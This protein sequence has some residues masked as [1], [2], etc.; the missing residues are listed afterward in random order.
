MSEW[1]Q[2]LSSSTSSRLSKDSPDAPNGSVLEELADVDNQS[3]LQCHRSPGCHDL[4]SFVGP[5]DPPD[6]L[7]WPDDEGQ[8]LPL[9]LSQLCEADKAASSPGVPS[10]EQYCQAGNS[11]TPLQAP[12][13]LDPASAASHEEGLSLAT[14][15]SHSHDVKRAGSEAGCSQPWP[16]VQD[17]TPMSA[18][19]LCL[20]RGSPQHNFRVTGSSLW[21]DRAHPVSSLHSPPA[22]AGEPATS[23]MLPA[24]TQQHGR[25]RQFSTGGSVVGRSDHTTEV[26]QQCLASCALQAQHG[27]HAES[28]AQ[29]QLTA[30]EQL[31]L[32]S[33]L[34]A[35]GIPW[36]TAWHPARWSQ[37]VALTPPP[38]STWPATSEMA[39]DPTALAGSSHQQQ[40][41]MQ[42]QPLPP[43]PSL[44]PP[45][46]F[47][48]GA[49]SFTSLPG[50]GPSSPPSLAGYIAS[51]PTT[52]QQRQQ[53]Q[54]QQCAVDDTQQP[55]SH[56]LQHCYSEDMNSLSMGA[57]RSWAAPGPCW[58]HPAHQPAPAHCS[59]D[60]LGRGR[61]H[62]L[63]MQPAPTLMPAAWAQPSP[64]PPASTQCHRAW[65]NIAAA[66]E[67]DPAS[68]QPQP[69]Q[70]LTPTAAQLLDEGLTPDHPPDPPEASCM[71]AHACHMQF[72]RDSGPS[73]IPREAARE[74]A[75]DLEDL[76]RHL[77][78][79]RSQRIAAQLSHSPTSMPQAC[80]WN[81]HPLGL[82]LTQCNSSQP[83]PSAAPHYQ[84]LSQHCNTAAQC[85]P[86]S[87][88]RVM[89]DEQGLSSSPTLH[90][91]QQPMDYLFRLR[92]GFSASAP[93]LSPF[94]GH[95]AAAFTAGAL[96][97]APL[98]HWRTQRRPVA[99]G[100]GTQRHGSASPSFANDKDGHQAQATQP[101]H[102]AMSHLSLGQIRQYDSR[103]DQLGQARA[104]PLGLDLS[105]SCNEDQSAGWGT[106]AGG[107]GPGEQP[108]HSSP[109]RSA[110]A[111]TRN[112]SGRLL[113]ARA[114]FRGFSG[115]LLRRPVDA[116]NQPFPDF[117]LAGADAWALP[118]V[119][120]FTGAPSG[121]AIPRTQWLGLPAPSW[122]SKE[123]SVSGS[124]LGNEVGEAAWQI[125]AVPDPH[126]SKRTRQ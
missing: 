110:G 100:G 11:H 114:E 68:F 117:A 61:S 31:T 99:A 118:H 62:S 78:Q 98:P 32:T 89:T 4:H 85:H 112:H 124:E 12:Q 3:W 66:P 22:T 123:F 19:R 64:R 7:R 18:R 84:P 23:S 94:Q 93:L 16:A 76:R 58:P 92:P 56:T 37:D 105:C 46:Q 70:L 43:P 50:Q 42:Q 44:H 90:Q 120:S 52:Q 10:L 104:A 102:W 59:T 40:C 71:A 107:P 14:F 27:Q 108:K 13:Q 125:G 95:T 34:C 15:T 47:T 121:R 91:A 41:L 73:A 9:D 48:A 67:A 109:W 97:D 30:L 65:L 126:A 5:A 38:Q 2:A 116:Y 63:G 21:H 54:Q 101:A 81:S 36:A 86:G 72:N 17:G 75:A 69:P 80:P 6:L 88:M 35:N 119:A 96:P 106:H 24:A 74:L 60:H 122:L 28:S 33:P 26:E 77:L 87:H 113:P 8:H 39:A 49:T 111:D 53:Q 103:P 29:T 79:R 45:L 1:P 51:V 115:R 82:D 20:D 83:S 55:P 57:C 25:L